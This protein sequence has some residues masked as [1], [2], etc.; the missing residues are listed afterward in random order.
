[1]FSLNKKQKGLYILQLIKTSIT[2]PV[3]TD[4]KSVRFQKEQN[5]LVNLWG[6]VSQSSDI[7]VLF[8]EEIMCVFLITSRVGG[9]LSFPILYHTL[10][11]L[12]GTF[13]HNMEWC[14]TCIRVMPTLILTQ[15]HI[16]EWGFCRL[17]LIHMERWLNIASASYSII[18]PTEQEKVKRVSDV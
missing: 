17:I 14:N 8:L 6:Y 10:M 3:T 11:R 9:W 15:L 1:M 16:F 5:P 12:Y 13:N 7:D 4:I 18:Q 2:S